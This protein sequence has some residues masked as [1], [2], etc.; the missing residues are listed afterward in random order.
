MDTGP[1]YTAYWATAE[2]LYGYHDIPGDNPYNV[3]RA[4]GSAPSVMAAAIWM[5]APAYFSPYIPARLMKPLQPNDTIG[6][7]A[8]PVPHNATVGG[9]YGSTPKRSRESDIPYI[10]LKAPRISF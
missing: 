4:V 7:S 10:G 8:P 1:D 2:G 3:H 6:R 5:P 9:A